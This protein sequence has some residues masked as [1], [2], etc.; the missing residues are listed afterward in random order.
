MLECRR[1][2]RAVISQLRAQ[3]AEAQEECK[4][5]KANLES[6]DR[7]HDA[8]IGEFEETVSKLEA[9]RNRFL[10]ELEKAQEDRDLYFEA[11]ATAR[12]LIQDL[13]KAARGIADK[14]A[15]EHAYDEMHEACDRAQAYLA[16]GRDKS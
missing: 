3:L 16:A 12:W 1:D 13:V 2:F 14:D 7:A 9:E 11:L 8:L 15:D 5:A 10:V 6:L 4:H